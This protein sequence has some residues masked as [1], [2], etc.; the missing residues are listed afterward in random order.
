MTRKILPL[1]GIILGGLLAVLPAS[2]VEAAEQDLCV[3]VQTDVALT[4]DKS[5]PKAAVFSGDGDIYLTT[6]DAYSHK[7]VA[8]TLP[9]DFEM[10]TPV[11][12]KA[13]PEGT[14]VTYE[15]SMNARNGFENYKAVNGLDGRTTDDIYMGKIHVSVPFTVDFLEYGPGSYSIP[16]TV[17]LQAQT[18]Y[19]SY[20]SDLTFTSWQDLVASGGINVYRMTLTQ[21]NKRDMILD[22]DPSIT[23]ISGSFTYS[24]YKEVD[25]PSSVTSGY[26]IFQSSPVEKIVFGEG[27]TTVPSGLCYYATELT[28]VVMP[29]TVH[30]FKS[31]CFRGC[32]NLDNIKLPA[33]MSLESWSF[34]N[35]KKITELH[36]TDGV[37]VNASSATYG[38]FVGSGLQKV[39]V[40]EGA[41]TVPKYICA[42]CTDVDEL[43]LPDTLQTM[44]YQCFT[45][46]QDLKEVTIKSDIAQ[47]NSHSVVPCFEDTGIETITFTHGVTK[48]GR[49]LFAGGC[50]HV[51]QLNL[52]DTLTE[53]GP[54][55]FEGCSSLAELEIPTSVTTLGGDCFQGATSLKEL[56]IR[57]DY[58]IPRATIVSPFEDSGIEKLVIEEGVTTVVSHM[59]DD[60]CTKMTELILP[61]TL[62]TIGGDAFENCKSL[63]NLTVRSNA[64]VPRYT[65][66]SPFEG[67]DLESITYVDGVTTVGA[68]LFNG[69]CA[70]LTELNLPDSLTEIKANA[71]AGC[72]SLTELEIPTSVRTLGGDSFEGATSL[73]ELHIRANYA[74]PSGSVVSPF[75]NSGIEKLVFEE[76]VT[77]IVAHLFDRGCS[78][79]TDLV[80]PTTVETVGGWAFR[81]CTSLKSLVVRSNLKPPYA[82]TVSPFEGG[83]IEHIEFTSGVSSVGD[84]IFSGAVSSMTTLILPEGMTALG[85]NAFE[86][87][88]SLSSLYI[89]TTMVEIE[90]EA[91]EGCTSLTTLNM[92]SSFKKP[93]GASYSPFE[94]GGI[95]VVNVADGLTEI[96]TNYLNNADGTQI[97][98]NIPVSVTKIGYKVFK[99]GT[100]YIA[101][102]DGTEEQWEA[103]EKD[104]SFAPAQV[105]CTDTVLSMMAAARQAEM[106]EEPE[107][108][109]GTD[110]VEMA[111]TEETSETDEDESPDVIDEPDGVVRL[112]ETES[113]DNAEESE[114]S[115]V[116]E[117]EETEETDNLDETNLPDEAD[118]DYE[119]P[120]ANTGEKPDMADTEKEADAVEEDVSSDDGAFTLTNLAEM[121]KGTEGME[122][123]AE[124]EEPDEAMAFEMADT[125]YLS[126]GETENAEI[127]DEPQEEEDM[128]SAQL[129]YLSDSSIGEL[130]ADSEEN[131]PDD[132]VIIS[133]EE[134]ADTDAIVS[135]P[136]EV[137]ILNQDAA[138]EESGVIGIER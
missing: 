95:T 67:G 93:T 100:D 83:D 107:E 71:F 31:D 94:N 111:G 44:G 22:I 54:N 65:V 5:D 109:E 13:A 118:G 89:P 70:S 7:F 6:E 137:S 96:K 124:T 23:G 134:S 66:V 17:T 90:M 115:D 61:T 131:I 121:E 42:G 68:Y 106:T 116:D 132:A 126:N 113:A 91:F 37:S 88:S 69:A 49:Y 53:I 138:S 58:A 20:S 133:L 79:V 122:E 19:G 77:S 87:C 34:A 127:A 136:D 82:T 63:K 56:H 50:S 27:S 105:I 43:Y 114:D 18:A 110:E 47:L 81:D 78:S 36:I 64:D 51:T 26:H 40:E 128:V 28:D 38:P 98:I 62:T 59:F 3:T 4:L 129:L 85:S 45:G 46:M 101:Y 60:G 57:A 92:N 125:S 41:T 2:G 108:P 48:V 104:S 12:K 30:T 102:Y 120:D 8:V 72:S 97:R 32:T 80:L 103:V 29:D 21:I 99:D 10:E 123:L 135:E 55:A 14:S 117:Q 9:E 24:T 11:G 16:I 15:G 25:I 76:G 84:Y 112:D 1:F 75:E 130:A 86:G 39:I 74:L 33:E 52:P 35:C 119:E 73:K